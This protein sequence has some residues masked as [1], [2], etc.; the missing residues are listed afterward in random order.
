MTKTTKLYN[1]QRLLLSLIQSFGGRLANIDLQKYLFLY[2]QIC[3]KEKSYEFVPYKY[4][5]FSFQSYADRR[6]LT[7]LGFLSDAENWLLSDDTDYFSTLKSEEARKLSLFVEKYKN[8]KGN[9]LVREVYIKFP[10]YATN[11]EIADSLLNDNELQKINDALP[12]ENGMCFFTI[13]YEG[14]SFEN[15]LNRLIKNNIVL[16]CDVRKN[17]ISRKFGFSQK[18]LSETLENLGIKYAHLPNLGIVS[19]KRKT[20]N[21]KADYNKLFN[22]YEKTTLKNNNHAL[23]ELYNLLIENKRIAITCFEADVCMCHRG[24]IAKALQNMPNWNI[25]THH[26]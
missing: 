18:K 12:K 20:L 14:T 13:G 26:I 24:R 2:T 11:S 19:N 5:G 3:Q 22:E 10:Y 23:Q 17:P 16:L 4:G 6:K 9:N 8:L 7:E 1:R 25:E 15:Y 21:T